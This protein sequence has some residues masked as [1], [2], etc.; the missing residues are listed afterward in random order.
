LNELEN[1][2]NNSNKFRL[3]SSIKSKW[4]GELT[5]FPFVLGCL[6][7]FSS[8]RWGDWRN[9]EKYYPTL[10]YVLLCNLIYKVIALSQFH[11]WQARDDIMGQPLAFFYYT[12]FTFIPGV[13]LY[14]SNYSDSIKKQIFHIVK[15]LSIFMGVEWI[16]YKYFNAINYFNGWTIWWS[17]IFDLMMLILIRI[18][19]V[20]YKIG[21]LLSIPCTFF[22]LWWFDYI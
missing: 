19:F 13:F 17:L 20:N 9:L 15:W 11:L 12:F 8:W 18:H 6:C 3:V 2:V 22:Y 4:K 21:F 14:L 16:G 1:S 5:I 7:L 10:L